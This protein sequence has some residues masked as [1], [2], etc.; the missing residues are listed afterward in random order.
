MVGPVSPFRKSII[1]W[2]HSSPEAGHSGRDGT[3]MRVKRRFYWKGM[4]KDIK[5]F[6]RECVVCQAAKYEP[7]A[8]PRLLQPLD[9]PEEVWKNV[10]MDFI[11]GLPKSMHRDTI[12]VV[13]ERLSKYAHFIPLTHPYTAVQVAQSYLD[14]VFK[15]HGWP[16][17]SLSDRDAV[18]MSHFWQALVSIHGTQFFFSLLIIPKMMARLKR[19]LEMYLRCICVNESKDWCKWLPLA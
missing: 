1:E 19:Y 15:L 2:H 8:S 11:T 14:N 16:R 12:I 17:S 13:V 10:S 3:T 7:I 6:V 9:I 18:F 5:Q 4:N